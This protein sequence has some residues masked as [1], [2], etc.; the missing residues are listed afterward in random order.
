MN[1]STTGRLDELEARVEAI[2]RV[3]QRTLEIIE[4]IGADYDAGESWK[5]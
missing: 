5:K 3:A 2:R 4:R 1:E